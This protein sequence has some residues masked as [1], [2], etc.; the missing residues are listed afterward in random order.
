MNNGLWRRQR[1]CACSSVV[2]AT[3]LHPEPV[4]TWRDGGCNDG[5][6]GFSEAVGRARGP[7]QIAKLTGNSAL[8]PVPSLDRTG[9][10]G[11]CAATMPTE[12]AATAS[13]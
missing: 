1:S 2:I 8:R 4:L 13:R 11:D 6:G 10:A 12:T 9:E 3:D 5:R 7:S